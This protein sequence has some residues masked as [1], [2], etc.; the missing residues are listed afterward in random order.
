MCLQ[1]REQ[2]DRLKL[3]DI[4]K[5]VD[6]DPNM[7]NLSKTKRKEYLDD[8]QFHRDEKKMGARSSNNAAAVDCRASI[9]KVSTEVCTPSNHISV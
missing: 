2:G 4:Q 8:L 1:D 5:L 3:S 7:Q 6:D 9:T